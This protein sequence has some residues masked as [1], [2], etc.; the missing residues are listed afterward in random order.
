MKARTVVRDGRLYATLA[1]LTVVLAGADMLYFRSVGP[2]P[3]APTALRPADAIA[4]G[5]VIPADSSFVCAYNAEIP[6]VAD[7]ASL[8]TTH[9]V[10]EGKADAPVTVI[11]F[12]EPNCPHCRHFYPV[13]K[14]VMA[15]Y[16]DRARFVVKPVVFWDKSVVQGQALYAAAQ[17]GKFDEMLALQFSNARP[18]GLSEADVKAIAAQIGLDGDAIVRGIENGDYR[19][20][21]FAAR[22][23]F[24]ASGNT[25]VPAVLINGRTVSH[26]SRTFACLGRLIEE[27]TE[28][29]A[30]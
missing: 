13:M 17:M 8:I 20:A 2:A 3:A 24:Q 21:A 19:P 1:V 4:P 16:G 26:E 11:E 28:T 18:N 5:P 7:Y 25:S 6:A 22:E 9:D 10:V 23:A 30:Q 29:A 14:Q 15:A 27:A 12:F